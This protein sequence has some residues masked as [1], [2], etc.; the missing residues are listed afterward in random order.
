[1][2][3]NSNCVLFLMS[4]F[5]SGFNIL[6][7][8]F[9]LSC[10]VLMNLFVELWPLNGRHWQTPR[11][12]PE[13]L[14]ATFIR[15]ISLSDASAAFTLLKKTPIAHENKTPPEAW[16]IIYCSNLSPD[17]KH[18]KDKDWS[19]NLTLEKWILMNTF[20]SNFKWLT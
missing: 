10:F 2:T 16:W 19:L 20:F 9:S 11:S 15:S 5:R 12:Q 6:P 1:M 18:N 13:L 7:I 3:L 8:T 4:V 17:Y 14:L